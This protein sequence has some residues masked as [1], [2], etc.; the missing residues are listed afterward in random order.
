MPKKKLD[1]V[2]EKDPIILKPIDD[3]DEDKV[4]DP[5]G[6]LGEEVVDEEDEVTMDDD[7]VD[8]FGDKWEQ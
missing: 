7:E 1:A 2:K 4:I 5:E 8:P 6:I 3:I